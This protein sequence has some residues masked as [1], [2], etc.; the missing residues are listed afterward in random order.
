MSRISGFE[1]IVHKEDTLLILGSMPSIESLRQ[2]MYYANKT[3]RFWPMLGKIYGLPYETREQ[4][5]E[6]VKSAKIAIWDVCQSC[7]RQTSADSKIKDIIPNDI[8]DL[9]LNNPSIQR[10]IC[11]GKTSYQTLKK[12][13]P[14]ID[15][16]SMPS[17]SAANAKY[18]LDDL[19]ALYQQY[20]KGE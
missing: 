8:P 13:Y 17:T 15:A 2:D 20:L 1:P 5:L 7:Q 12:Y 14:D 6:L 16:I 19:I 9:L 10:V 3:N 18:R 11:N 4:K